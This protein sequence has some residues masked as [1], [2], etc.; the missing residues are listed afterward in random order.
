MGSLTPVEI[1]EQYRHE[2][3]IWAG[4]QI[5]GNVCWPDDLRFYEEARVSANALSDTMDFNTPRLR[6]VF[7]FPFCPLRKMN[8]ISKM[9]AALHVPGLSQPFEEI[10]ARV[11][12]IGITTALQG[13]VPNGLARAMKAIKDKA[14]RPGSQ[15]LQTSVEALSG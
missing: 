14:A 9:V 8:L 13:T 10:F 1:E 4:L 5:T 15:H 6:L 7:R 3:S 11:L 2:I 12:H